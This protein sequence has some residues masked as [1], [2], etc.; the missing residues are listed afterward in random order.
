MRTAGG[1]LK[2]RVATLGNLALRG[3]RLMARIKKLP[4]SCQ[5]VRVNQVNTVCQQFSPKGRR[6]RRAPEPQTAAMLVRPGD[7]LLEFLFFV[8]WHFSCA[9]PF[10]GCAPIGADPGNEIGRFI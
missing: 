8:G 9:A 7:S 5:I 3:G 4:Q 2:V 10:E 1:T 6:V